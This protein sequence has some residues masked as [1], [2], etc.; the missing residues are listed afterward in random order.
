MIKTPTTEKALLWGLVDVNNFYASCERAF[1]P[2]LEGKP[3]VVLSNND[4]CI[5]ARSNEAK[6]LGIKMGVPAFKVADLLRKHQVEVFSSNYELYGDLSCRVMRNLEK[7]CPIDQYSIDECF[8]P[9]G[10]AMAIQAEEVARECK[11]VIKQNVWLPVSVGVGATRT[12]AKVANHRAKKSG[13][14]V[15]VLPPGSCEL[16]QALEQTPVEEVW[17]IGRR[18][19]KRLLGYGITTARHLRDM[20]PDLALR[21]LT[22][23]GQRTVFELRGEQCIML[24]DTPVPRKSMVS[25]R[26]FGSK[27][28]RKSD[29]AE[30]MAMHASMA[31]AKLRSEGL[32]AGVIAVFCS[33]SPFGDEPAHGISAR[34][35]LP[36]PTNDTLTLVSAARAALESCF[37]PG[38]YMKGGVMIV[39]LARESSRQ[40]TLLEACAPEADR[41]RSALMEALDTINSRFGRATVR[42]AAEGPRDACWHMKRARKSPNYTTNW[43]ELPKA[44]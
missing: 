20:D 24:D 2:E 25:S 31:A 3:I 9:F 44:R 23:V 19:A 29:L 15:L 37:R 18:F 30:A 12:L 26:S 5:V 7:I 42:T 1:R 21:V 39:E 27:I 8:I 11:R 43:Y 40:L 17:G 34:V 36:V 33:T 35:N 14:G 4:G 16:E 41:S 28:T 32:R 10:Q 38:A 22:V 13:D 6:A